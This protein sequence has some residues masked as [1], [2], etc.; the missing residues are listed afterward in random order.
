M[1][2]APVSP[3][4]AELDL[5]F[6]YPA[7]EQDQTVN[8]SMDTKQQE[9]LAA[10]KSAEDERAD[11]ASDTSLIAGTADEQEEKSYSAKEKKQQP[12]NLQ[13]SVESNKEGQTEEKPSE[14]QQEA[15]AAKKSEEDEHADKADRQPQGHYR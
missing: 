3:V 14:K 12:A 4:E 1:N 11:E 15:L 6:L 8:F 13:K 5:S 10:E 7:D 2:Q 9:A